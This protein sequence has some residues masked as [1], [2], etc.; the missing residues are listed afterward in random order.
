MT[1][2]GH[3]VKSQPLVE[4]QVPRCEG[5]QIT[6]STRKKRCTHS[7]ALDGWQ[8]TDDR[9]GVTGNTWAAS[10][11][12]TVHHS[13]IVLVSPRAKYRGKVL[14]LYLRLRGVDIAQFRV[15]G[16]DAAASALRFAQRVFEMESQSPLARRKVVPKSSV[17]AL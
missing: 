1:V 8:D 10:G 15:R 13:I 16:K 5:F 4:P 14:R 12:H 7:L 9:P 11:A 6:E 3:L 2:F 17:I